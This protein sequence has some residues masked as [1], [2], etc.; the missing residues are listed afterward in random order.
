MKKLKILWVMGLAA[1]LG[2]AEPTEIFRLDAVDER[3][4]ARDRI[5]PEIPFRVQ[6]AG[7]EGKVTMEFIVDKEGR[8]IDPKVLQS[9]NPWFERPAL[10]A[11]LQWRYTPGKKDGK[12]VHTLCQQAILFTFEGGGAAPW[13][14]SKPK[15]APSLPPALR[16]DI[17]PTPI[18]TAF[19]VWPFEAAMKDAGGRVKVTFVIGPDGRILA[20]NATEATSTEL[21]RAA[22]AAIDVWEF[23]PARKKD[24][25]PCGAVMSIEYEFG[26]RSDDAPTSDSAFEILRQLRQG[27]ETKFATWKDLDAALKPLSRRRPVYPSALR[28]AGQDGEAVIEF[29]IDEQ[30]DAQLPRI[31]SATAPEFGYAAA[32][33]VATWRF[34][35]PRR[36]G[37]PAVVRAKV[38]VTFHLADRSTH[39]SMARSP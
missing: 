26:L 5:D 34:T 38:P 27:G 4:R 36:G 15:E 6:N 11:I 20:A 13:S 28:E 12:S 9:N 21:G 25:S 16:W 1:L 3:P 30:G 24:G 2:R 31:V 8:V 14:V 39:P 32:Q 22:L 33:A 29:F 7:V 23:Q 17:A 35:R 19:P 37:K 18:S 10:D